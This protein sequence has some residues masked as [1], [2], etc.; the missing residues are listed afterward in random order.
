M[1]KNQLP[2]TWYYT[3]A[4]RDYLDFIKENNVNFLGYDKNQ[5]DPKLVRSSILELVYSNSRYAILK[6]KDP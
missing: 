1:A 3:M 5:L 2:I 4:S 6:V